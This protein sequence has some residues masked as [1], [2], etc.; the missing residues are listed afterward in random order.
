MKLEEGGRGLFEGTIP[1]GCNFS[2]LL[3]LKILANFLCSLL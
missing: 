2:K 1:Y 3:T